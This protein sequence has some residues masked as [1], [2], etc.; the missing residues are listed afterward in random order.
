VPIFIPQQ[1]Q[2]V[3]QQQ[4]PVVAKPKQAR[5]KPK[6]SNRVSVKSPTGTSITHSELIATINGNTSSLQINSSLNP[7]NATLFPWLSGPAQSFDLWLPRRIV[8]RYVPRC[9]T[10]IAGRVAMAFDYDVTDD[11]SSVSFTKLMQMRGAVSCPVYQTRSMPY[12]PNSTVLATHKYYCGDDQIDRLMCPSRLLVMAESTTEGPLGDIFID[13]TIAL[14]DP[15]PVLGLA[16]PTLRITNLDNATPAA[17]LGN[18]EGIKV[19]TL[20]SLAHNIFTSRTNITTLA[21]EGIRLKGV[22]ERTIGAFTSTASTVTKFRGF[23]MP[24]LPDPSQTVVFVV[25]PFLGTAVVDISIWAR[26]N[27]A[28]GAAVMLASNYQLSAPRAYGVTSV[29]TQTYNVVVDVISTGRWYTGQTLEDL[30]GLAGEMRVTADVTCTGEAAPCMIGFWFEALDYYVGPYVNY[31][32]LVLSNTGLV[33]DTP[34]VPDLT[35]EAPLDKACPQKPTN[36]SKCTHTSR[37]SAV[38]Q[39]SRKL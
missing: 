33:R 13:Y 19:E 3:P 11:D 9:G 1:Q 18:L 26:W 10:L 24:S 14:F 17:P 30:E 20:D 35:V 31:G 36:V 12:L 27:A 29:G 6:A 22:L 37:S 5:T 25:P 16:I 15:E 23:S 4:Q 28:E 7:R 39:P 8:I 2:F 38:E 32:T 21:T 34:I